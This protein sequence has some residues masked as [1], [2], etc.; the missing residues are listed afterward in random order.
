MGGG[1]WGRIKKACPT[2]FIAYCTL[3]C[4]GSG[5]GRGVRTGSQGSAGVA[6]SCLDSRAVACKAVF[7]RQTAVQPAAKPAVKGL[8]SASCEDGCTRGQDTPAIAQLA[9]QARIRP[10]IAASAPAAMEKQA[11]H[12]AAHRL[13]RTSHRT[14]EMNA[15]DILAQGRTAPPC[16]RSSFRETLCLCAARVTNQ[17]RSELGIQ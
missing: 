12:P 15:S 6:A 13:W 7:L 5:R 9:A 17:K 8:N 10:A 1:G 2:G 11:T 4:R 3:D 16:S 14:R